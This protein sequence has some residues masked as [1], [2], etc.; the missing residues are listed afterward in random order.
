MGG[1]LSFAFVEIT[2]PEVERDFI[3]RTLFPLLRLRQ[4]ENSTF[5]IQRGALSAYKFLASYLDQLI[6]DPTPAAKLR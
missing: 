2:L 6:H 1:R 5:R 3:K 4:P